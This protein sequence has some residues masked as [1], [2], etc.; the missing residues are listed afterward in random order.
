MG[1][2]PG[3]TSGNGIVN[4]TDVTQAKSQSGQPTTAANFRQDVNNSGSI[5]S[6]D[7]ST[8]KAKSGTALP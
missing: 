2:L 5:N 4:S 6:T 7:V 3:D 1:L 8:V